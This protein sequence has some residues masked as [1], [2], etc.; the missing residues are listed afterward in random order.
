MGNLK[1]TYQNIADILSFETSNDDLKKT[2]SNPL[3]NWDNIVIEGS[4]HLVLPAIYCRLK[5][6]QLLYLLPEELLNYLK[7][8][9][10]LNEDRNLAI[11]DQINTL[12]HLLKTHKIEH[13]FLKGSALLMGDFYEAISERMLGDIDILI[14]EDQLDIAF[15]L[16]KENGYI[17]IEQTLGNS[18]F[19]HKH[20]PRLMTDKNICAVELHRKLFVTYRDND[21]QNENILSEKQIY[22]TINLPSLAHL[23][24]HNVLNYQIN[25][26][27]KL[28]NSISFRP[29]YDSVILLRKLNFETNILG[30]K[31]FRQY[32]TI[33]SL[34]FRDIKPLRLKKNFVAKFYLFKLKHLKF[35]KFWNKLLN[36]FYYFPIF[37]NRLSVFIS[38]KAYR[39]AVLNDR[40]RIFKHFKTV[41]NNRN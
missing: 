41:I 29:A 38:N 15:N 23:L 19:E 27:G 40:K 9:A 21:L 4:K 24:R 5:S 28:H 39:T 32:F 12:S 6:K 8:L 18:F 1:T 11:K 17:P 13:V 2:L 25:D 31:I 10:T 20:L 33:L 3:F 26:N 7:E 14:K 37:L 36:L 16:L 35:Y 22:N 30:H 34:F